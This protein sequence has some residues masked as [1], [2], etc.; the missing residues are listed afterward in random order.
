MVA[1]PS[2]S[3]Q[4]VPSAQSAQATPVVSEA[5]TNIAI[6]TPKPQ[7]SF[8]ALL[9]KTN[10]DTPALAQN[11]IVPLNVPEVT[12][13]ANTISKVRNGDVQILNMLQTGAFNANAALVAGQTIKTDVQ[14]QSDKQLSSGTLPKSQDNKAVDPV[15]I[16]LTLT[17]L[18]N[19]GQSATKPPVVS[20]SQSTVKSLLHKKDATTDSEEKTRTTE[21][22]KPTENPALSFISSAL[23]LEVPLEKTYL[24]AAS[25]ALLSKKPLINR[26]NNEAAIN[27]FDSE[28]ISSE[29][30]SINFQFDKTPQPVNVP[31]AS[32]AFG[33]LLNAE[34]KAISH[35]QPTTAPVGSA[36]QNFTPVVVAQPRAAHL[37]NIVVLTPHIATMAHEVGL[38]IAKASQAGKTEFTIRLD[39][40]ELGRIEIKL[41]MDHDGKVQAIL[42]SDNPQTHDLLRK[43]SSNLERALT[44]SG[45]KTEGSALSFNLRDQNS[46]QRENPFF[47]N[48]ELSNGKSSGKFFSDTDDI[49]IKK[50]QLSSRI[51]LNDNRIDVI[52]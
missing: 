40:A 11:V 45:L 18:L 46:N 16:N 47:W 35:T 33:S 17:K 50:V 24:S 39:P 51:F 44:D 12:I 23:P 22:S 15:D 36:I 28:K 1:L 48:D 30:K 43:E 20:S 21:T 9:A 25:T 49:S 29:S 32:V 3:L 37:Q 4:N 34:S 8:A 13:A 52:A 14:S 10:I 7:S 19:P 27:K 26:T 5:D 42:S 41:H 31:D 2:V 38:E 6:D